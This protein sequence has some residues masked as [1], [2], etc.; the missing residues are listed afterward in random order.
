MKNQK[1]PFLL[2]LNSSFALF[3]TVDAE[4]AIPAPL[5]RHRRCIQEVA[6]REDCEEENHAPEKLKQV[7]IEAI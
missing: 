5:K 2:I 7:T 1:D 3:Y 6:H 4:Q